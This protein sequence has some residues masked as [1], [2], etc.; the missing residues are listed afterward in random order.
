MHGGLKIGR[1]YLEYRGV[2]PQ[3]TAEAAFLCPTRA[4]CRTLGGRGRGRARGQVDIATSYLVGSAGRE[5]VTEAP[6]A[7]VVLPRFGVDSADEL[8]SQASTAVAAMAAD[9]S[10]FGLDGG[11]D[12][13]ALVH[14]LRRQLIGR[15]SAVGET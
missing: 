14:E 5:F 9:V 8:R 4:P 11:D 7:A 10:V 15:E 3:R 6:L 2:G 12:I 1:R 13:E